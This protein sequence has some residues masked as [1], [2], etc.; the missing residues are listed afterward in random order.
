[1]QFGISEGFA[2]ESETLWLHQALNELVF[3]RQESYITD[4]CTVKP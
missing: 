2:A 4:F 3:M 1:M